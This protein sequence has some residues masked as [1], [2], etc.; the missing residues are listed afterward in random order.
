[1]RKFSIRCFVLMM[2][3]AIILTGCSGGTPT[4]PSMNFTGNWT[5]TNT[6]NSSAFGNVGAT[7]T[8][9]CTIDDNNG[10]LTISN[11]RIVD[12]PYYNWNVGYGTRS[13]NY[14]SVNVTGSYI[15]TYGDT[16]SVTIYFEGEI[17]SN[18]INGIGTWVQTISIYGDIQSASGTTVFVKG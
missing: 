13:G 1:M 6:I 18:G 15:N 12:F 8:A 11:F 7:T 4:G 3:I 14:L 17:N 5:M 9:K 10:S 16:V 2:I